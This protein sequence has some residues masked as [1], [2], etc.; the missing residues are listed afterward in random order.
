MQIKKKI[1][2]T[3]KPFKP[4]LALNNNSSHLTFNMKPGLYT[5][6]KSYLQRDKTILKKLQ[7]TNSQQRLETVQNAL[8]R[9]FFLELTQSFIIPL[10]RYFSSL[11]P[12]QK[13]YQANREPPLI[14]DFDKEEFLKTI[15][16]YGPQLTSGLKGDWKDLYKHFLSTPNF[17]LWLLN[18]QQ[19]ANAK[20]YSLYIKTLAYCHL[21][22]DLNLSQL[23]EL[24][25]I[26][27]VIKFR[28]LIQRIEIKN[29]ERLL[30][31]NQ[32]DRNDY[33]EKLKMKMKLIIDENLPDDMKILF[34]KS[35]KNSLT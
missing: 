30:T 21:E 34:N 22:Q 8:L 12:L 7:P 24:E 25:L 32:V 11:L 16:Q 17:R 15:D 20:I 9:R 26:D 4:T 10:E 28:D 18:R 5:K 19:E 31:L 13:L 1:S 27:L 29:D 14:K 2:T 23:K 33:L 35:I 6:Y 3:S